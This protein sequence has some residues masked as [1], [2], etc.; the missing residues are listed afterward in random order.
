MKIFLSGAQGTGKSS[1]IKFIEEN[2]LLPELK[3]YDSYSKKFLADKGEQL[4]SSDNFLNFQN[5]IFLFCS[6]VYLNEN[7]FISS[8]GFADSYA[9]I[10]SA[11][12]KSEDAEIKSNLI[13][14]GESIKNYTKLLTA[15]KGVYNFYC[16][17]EFELT[18]SNNDLRIEGKEF[19]R[20]IDKL[21]MEYF[22][23]NKVKVQVLHGSQKER[24]HQIL[25][26]I[27]A[28]GR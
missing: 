11:L 9:Y 16:P 6:N 24:V 21:I 17:I 26:A 25:T 15:E 18:G 12:T 22:V 1:I 28:T 5:R 13:T 14:L 27:Y 2:K 3:K 10:A 19:Q 8:R 7:N 23:I 20:E 4:P